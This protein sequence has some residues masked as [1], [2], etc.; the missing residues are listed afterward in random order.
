MSLP[1]MRK[2]GGRIRSD[3][4]DGCRLQFN[5]RFP[6]ACYHFK[7]SSVRRT[8]C[9]H[10]AAEP[11]E[12]QGVPAQSRS[13]RGQSQARPP[14]PGQPRILCRSPVVLGHP[15]PPGTVWAVTPERCSWLGDGR[16]A[17]HHPTTCRRRP[18]RRV[19]LPQMSGVVGGSGARTQTSDF[20]PSPPHGTHKPTTEILQHTTKSIFCQ[21]GKKKKTAILL[22]HSYQVVIIVLAVVLF[23]F[24]N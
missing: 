18:R 21:S 4:D 12:A 6:G 23:L 8:Y 15:P 7:M 11:T 13:Y 16:G 9:D 24:G 17:A 20:P 22:I 1:D 14:R 10:A 19:A 5:F 2:L 3:I